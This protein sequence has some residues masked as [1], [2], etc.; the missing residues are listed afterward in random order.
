[1]SQLRDLLTRVQDTYYESGQP[2]AAQL[3][4]RTLDIPL[5]EAY[6]ALVSLHSL[7]MVKS[8]AESKYSISRAYPK[9]GVPEIQSDEVPSRSDPAERLFD[10][11][12]KEAKKGKSILPEREEQNGPDLDPNNFN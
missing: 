6:Q 2:E 1:M 9:P 4:Q 3:I 12:L 10:M 5:K 11:A 7:G 8:R